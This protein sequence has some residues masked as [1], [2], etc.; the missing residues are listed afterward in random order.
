[1]LLEI[2]RRT[3]AWV[4]L[5][6][7]ALLAL[8]YYQSKPRVVPRLA[9]ALLP[10]AMIGFS[11]Y[12]VLSSFRASSFVIAA[13]LIGIGLALGLGRA[14]PLSRRASYSPSSRSFAIP[15]SWAPLVL[16]MTIFFTRYIVAVLRARN[17]ALADVTLFASGV[18]LVYGFL[19]GIF[20]AGAVSLW[21]LGNRD[22]PA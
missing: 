22:L 5:L 9:I 18:S 6:F 13:W 19:S 14:V 17:P 8:G 12:G 15:G 10:S 1:M 21:R 16:M 7:L 11:A 3:P 20:L 2:L 4:Y